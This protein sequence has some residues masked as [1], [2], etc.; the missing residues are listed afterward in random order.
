MR[1][2]PNLRQ[3]QGVTLSG[4]VVSLTLIAAIAVPA[5]KIAPDVVEY[6]SI[7][8]AIYVARDSGESVPQIVAAFNRQASVGYITILS[9]KDLDIFK[10]KGRFVVS[11]AYEKKIHLVGPVSFIVDF[12]GSTEK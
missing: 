2:F 11:F 3:Q 1:R 5:I 6:A 4:V 12:T 7:K 10:D 9:G 8:K